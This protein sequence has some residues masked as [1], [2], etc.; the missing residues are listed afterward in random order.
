MRLARVTGTLWGAK[1]ADSLAGRR[2]VEARPVSLASWEPGRSIGD[3]APDDLLEDGSILA[4]DPLGADVGQ[5]VLV[6]VGSRVRD[7]C[8]GREVATKHCVVAIVDSAEHAEGA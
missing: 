2:I 5:L 8:L 6:A 7:L 3:D 4:V 1:Q